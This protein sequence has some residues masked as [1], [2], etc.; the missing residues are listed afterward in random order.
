MINTFKQFPWLTLVLVLLAIGIGGL[1]G[2]GVSFF[3]DPIYVVA[4]VISIV[5]A[6]VCLIHPKIG[7]YTLVAITYL[8][9]SD[10]LVN[11]YG[12]PSIA[13]PFISLMIGIVL[14][15]WWYHERPIRGTI[16]ASFLVFIYGLVIILSIFRASDFLAVQG[17]LDDFWKNAVIAIIVVSLLTES[18]TLRNVI[19]SLIVIG[20]FLGTISVIQYLTKT[21]ENPYWGFGI[22]SLQ[23]IAG[24]SEGYRIAGPI[25]DPNYYSQIMLALAPLAFSRFLGEKNF[26]L[27]AIALYGTAVTIFAVIFTFS[28][29]AFIAFSVVLMVMFYFHPPKPREFL[30]MAVLVVFLLPFVPKDYTSRILTLDVFGDQNAIQN[31]SSLRGRSSEYLAAWMMFSD[32]PIL[33][34]GVSNFETNYQSYSR[35]IGLDPRTQARS[36]HSLYLEIAAEL[37]LAGLAVMA[38]I[39]ITIYRSI[40]RA[41]NDFRKVGDMYHSEMVFSVGLSVLG[42]LVAATFIHDAYPRYF[43]L[44]IG[45]GLSVT[46]IARNEI[47]QRTLQTK[48][49]VTE[50]K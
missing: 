43:W 12:A 1:L 47:E 32:H 28:R 48:T 17:A 49:H 14:V 25:G 19:W 11:F 7:L 35:Q 3:D 37:G 9:L 6:L 4:G 18:K 33:G 31:D 8:R 26:I 41:W 20:I 36:A 15:R 30:I 22:S 2:L 21:Y 42:Y 10:V 39:L 44:L 16:Q 38:T 34:V 50:R 24:A 40:S 46:E 27:K 45:I 13:K 29:G 23:T 5:A